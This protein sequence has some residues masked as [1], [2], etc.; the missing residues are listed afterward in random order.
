MRSCSLQGWEERAL[1]GQG[2]IA[3]AWHVSIQREPQRDQVSPVT[4]KVRVGHEDLCN[5]GV[6]VQTLPA[7][8]VKLSLEE[9]K[10]PQPWPCPTAAPRLLPLHQSMMHPQVPTLSPEKDRN[11]SHSLQCCW[12]GEGGYCSLPRVLVQ[13]NAHSRCVACPAS[14]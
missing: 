9:P 11:Q 10:P 6:T 1:A 8:S 12:P 3:Q 5:A 2:H 14:L 13:S 7:H 4:Q